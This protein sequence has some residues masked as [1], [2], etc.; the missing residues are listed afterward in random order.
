[1]PPV[2]VVSSVVRTQL[3]QATAHAELGIGNAVGDSSRDNSLE[4]VVTDIGV[5][6]RKRKYYVPSAASRVDPEAPKDSSIRED[7]R[8]QGIAITQRDR[9]HMAAIVEL[10]EF[11]E[12]VSP[13]SVLARGKHLAR[14]LHRIAEFFHD[15]SVRQTATSDQVP[16][17][18]HQLRAEHRVA[19]D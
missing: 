5:Q 7:L 18:A 16:D 9:L 12:H 1:C 17:D 6:I 4:R 14:H 3:V 13:P 8:L 11:L 10:P 19:L 2:E 15:Q